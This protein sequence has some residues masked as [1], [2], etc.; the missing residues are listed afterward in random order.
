VSIPGNDKT[1]TLQLTD[2]KGNQVK[3]YKATGEKIQLNLPAMASGTYYLKVVKTDGS[4][5]HK[6]VIE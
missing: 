4:S 1:I 5:T 6:I 2:N 3:S